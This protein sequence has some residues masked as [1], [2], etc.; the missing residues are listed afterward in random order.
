MQENSTKFNPIGLYQ[1]PESKQYIGALDSIQADAMVQ[2]GYKLV[3]E[4]RSVEDVLDMSKVENLP[5]NEPD[6]TPEPSKKG[7]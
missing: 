5:G 6:A 2:Q 1:D 3:R 7:K 4:A